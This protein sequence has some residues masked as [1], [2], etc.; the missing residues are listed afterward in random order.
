MYKRQIVIL[1]LI[2]VSAIAGADQTNQGINIQALFDKENMTY[3]HRDQLNITVTAD[4]DCYFK[5]IHI[6]A[7]NQMKMIYPNSYDKN[8]ELKADMPRVIFETASYF[9]YAPYGEETLLLAASAEQFEKIEQEYIAPWIPATDEAV[10]A[11]VRGRRGG[12]LEQR[13]IQAAQTGEG[14]ASYT[15]TI[16]KPNEEYEYGRPENMAATVQAMRSDA[17]KQGGTFEG[18]ETSGYSVVN[19]V[20]VSYRVPSNA[21]D[22]VQFAFYNLENVSGGKSAKRQTRGSNYNFSFEKPE[23]IAQTIQMVRNGIEGKGGTFTGNEQQGSFKARGISGQYRISKLVNVTI[24]D[25][26]FL[27]PNSLIEREV[28]NY[29]GGM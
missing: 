28:K 17:L 2:A 13:I 29:F 19:N 3:F 6:D 7:D 25:K 4:K 22:T 1:M 16:L 27:I 9:L 23:N 20:R 15:I 21:P 12:E 26:P 10:R 11:A 18:N 8:N 24:T 5:I 14:A